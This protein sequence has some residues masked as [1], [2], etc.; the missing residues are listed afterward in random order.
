[1]KCFNGSTYTMVWYGW[2]SVEMR[3][4]LSLSMTHYSVG[5]R[6]SWTIFFWLRDFN[7]IAWL[8]D[9][10]MNLVF[11]SHPNNHGLSLHPPL[12]LLMWMANGILLCTHNIPAMSA[13]QH[14]IVK[15]TLI[16]QHILPTCQPQVLFSALIHVHELVLCGITLPYNKQAL[17][18]EQITQDCYEAIRPSFWNCRGNYAKVHHPTPRLSGL[19]NKLIPTLHQRL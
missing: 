13:I 3:N 6:C 18:I 19:L 1:M 12:P 17:H 5:E 4:D 16:E 10:N 7:I 15:T 9:M 8:A 11:S 14:I 2:T